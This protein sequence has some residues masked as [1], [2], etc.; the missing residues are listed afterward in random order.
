M[1]FLIPRKPLG[2]SVNI[3]APSLDSADT[4]QHNRECQDDESQR[5][6]GVLDAVVTKGNQMLKTA[7][8]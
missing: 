1:R 5:A 6:S 8:A 4:G 7:V 2:R 3:S